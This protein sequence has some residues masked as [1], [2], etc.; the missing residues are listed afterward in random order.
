MTS[1][2]GRCFVL[3]L[4]LGTLIPMA[5]SPQI[6]SAG[7][8]VGQVTDPQTKAVPGAEVRLTDV[9]TR[10]TRTTFTNDAGRYI[11]LDLAPGVYTATVGKEGFAQA[12][13]P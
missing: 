8:V 10:V 1:T 11:F 4:V 12:Q 6:T 2:L 9:A 5:A 13:L 3:C 7:A